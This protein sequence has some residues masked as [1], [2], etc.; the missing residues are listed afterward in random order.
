ME[1]DAHDAHIAMKVIE[2]A[3]KNPGAAIALGT[4]VGGS[5][6]GSIVAT[7]IA[8]VETI[9]VVGTAITAATGA[10]IVAA[11]PFVIGGAVAIGV[12]GW[13]FGGDNSNEKSAQ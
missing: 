12:L 4:F 13:L 3:V 6:G 1:L 10:A 11:A 9:G 8:A 5:T 2:E 7:G